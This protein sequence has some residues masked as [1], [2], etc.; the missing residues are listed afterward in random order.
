VPSWLSRANR[1]AVAAGG[2]ASA[3]PSS[4]AGRAER[5]RHARRGA[6]VHVSLLGYLGVRTCGVRRSAVDRDSP[7]RPRTHAGGA[8]RFYSPQHV[9]LY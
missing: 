7:T 4:A 1:G 6:G 9:S 3:S 5:Q 2:P 8:C